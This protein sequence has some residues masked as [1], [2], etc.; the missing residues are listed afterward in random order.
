MIAT[1]ESAP[2]RVGITGVGSCVPDTVM[3]NDDIAERVQTNHD[4]I[5]ERTGIHQRH[6]AGPGV[7]ASDLAAPAA[8]LAL[9]RAGLE[10]SD[11]DLVIVATITPD[12]PF[13]ATA[14]VV[15]DRIGAGKVAAYD[16]QAGCTGFVY[17]LT[18]AYS[19]IVAGLAARVL[20]V[21]VDL[22]T[23][24]VDWDDRGTCILFGDGA[25]AGIVEEVPT[26]GFL[27]FELGNDGA[28]VEDL[29]VP[30]GG[31]R[32]PASEATVAA[33]DH[34][35]RMNG[36]Q[37]FK[38]ATRVMVTSARRAL[39]AA[40]FEPDDVDLYVPHQANKRI[41]DHAVRELGIPEE[42]VV[43]NVDRF[44]NTSAASIPICLDEMTEAGQLTAGARVLMTGVG[45]GLT[46]G[47][48]LIDWPAAVDGGASA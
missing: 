19:T 21:G 47:S 1:T 42:K 3:T 14:S 27:S 12:M 28:G 45:T 25:G 23:N 6:V 8:E 11:I 20:V 15:A 10:A 2:I 29:Y 24:Y 32:R 38:F 13:P 4:W 17:A 9:K 44:G 18:Q 39:D 7:A 40:G 41:I 31:T 16:L 26:G 35:M 43:V 37:V 48:A 33:N 22:L 46:W 5:V 34:T 36:R 30:A